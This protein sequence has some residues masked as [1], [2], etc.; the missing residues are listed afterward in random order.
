MWLFS[1]TF[2][3]RSFRR[4]IFGS[5][6]LGGWAIAGLGCRIVFSVFW[7]AAITST[8]TTPTTAP[9]W[10]IVIVFA[11]GLSAGFPT[12]ALRFYLTVFVI[13]SARF[14]FLGLARSRI[15]GFTF[16]GFP[17][18]GI[19]TATITSA[20]TTTALFIAIAFFE[21]CRWV[22][23]HARGAGAFRLV[24]Q[25]DGHFH[26]G[27][28]GINVDG[29]GDACAGFNIAEL[30]A[31]LVKQI[32]RHVL[33]QMRHQFAMAKF[34]G[35]FVDLAQHMQGTALY[36]THHAG[37]ITMHTRFATAFENASAHALARHFHQAKR[38]NTTH[39]NARPI[40]FQ[41]FFHFA[42]DR[43]IVTIFIHVDEIDN[44]QA[45]QITQ[46]RLAGHFHSRL[47][48]GVQGGFLNRL[49]AGRFA[50]VHIN[51]DQR[52]GWID[53]QIAARW[54]N[55]GW[56]KHR[57]QFIFDAMLFEQRRVFDMLFYFARMAR[58][59]KLHIAFGFF[60]GIGASNRHFVKFFRV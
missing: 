28:L 12:R 46:P 1:T 33:R 4:R 35:T 60:I 27:Q 20:A 50:R 32:N 6:A 29:H 55:H 36:R 5:C 57:G 13:R 44:Q 59:Q 39:L 22:A 42:L 30:R 52:F 37:A 24:W 51:R 48:V 47:E 2:R 7:T 45:S 14:G 11:T 31:F 38:A 49:L 56:V 34:R 17:L 3:R 8:A 16:V 26:R 58:H 21:A 54:Q 10:L 19:G 25:R 40:A 18:I 23:F 43:P 15:R 41:R 53:N 9:L